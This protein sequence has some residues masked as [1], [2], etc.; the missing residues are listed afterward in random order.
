[1]PS[2]ADLFIRVR[3]DYDKTRFKGEIT[4]KVEADADAA[5][6]SSGQRMGRSLADKFVA[7]MRT[8]HPKLAGD[9]SAHLG[10]AGYKSGHV[11]ALSF[12]RSMKSQLG[13][14]AAAQ[15]AGTLEQAGVQVGQKF[16]TSM[17]GSIAA[18]IGDSFSPQGL[19]AVA[20]VGAAVAF[21]ATVLAPAMSAALLGGL[22]LGLLGLGAVLVRGNPAIAGYLSSIKANIAAAFSGTADP[23]IEPLKEAIQSLGRTAVSL[24]PAVKGMFTAI[25]PVIVPLADAVG[26]LVRNLM[27]GLTKAVVASG[28]VILAI[29]KAL[30]GLGSS[31]SD[32]LT[33]I[34]TAAPAAARFISDMMIGLGALLSF[35]GRVVEGLSIAYLNIVRS[36]TNVRR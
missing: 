5:G 32:F 3:P 35:A 17:M 36:V 19:I 25:A 28:P 1:M 20:L 14:Q 2:L 27:P 33:S 11:S 9:L 24:A 34:A 12:I 22:G 21:A 26:Q 10:N 4:P 13:E 6:K 31:L 8:E 18:D 23:L 29:A 15:L 30:P 16:G 7:Q